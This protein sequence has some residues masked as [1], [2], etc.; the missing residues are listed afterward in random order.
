M[1]IVKINNN[2]SHKLKLYL[3]WTYKD[4]GVVVDKTALLTTT[5]VTNLFLGELTF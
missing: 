2:N 3:T 5:F 4:V 1:F